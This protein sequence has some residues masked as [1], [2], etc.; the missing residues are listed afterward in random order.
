MSIE[1]FKPTENPFSQSYEDHIKNYWKFIC[2]LPK[3]KNPV[4]DNNG[5]KDEIVN[6]NSNAPVFYLN[7]SRN[8]GSF[9]ERTCKVPAGKGLFIPVM[10][11]EVSDKEVQNSTPER[12]KTIAKK[13]QDSVK[14]D[15]SVRL[16]GNEVSNLRSFRVSTDVFQIEFPENAIFDV[17]P[18]SSQ[19]VADGFY[20]ITKPL[21][22]GTH[23]IDFKG[24]LESTEEDSIEQNYSVNVKYTLEVQ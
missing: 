23:T 10:C 1:I 16:D 6:Q 17:S 21:S 15:L 8:G 22:P 11:V 9:V 13:D 2:R 5:Q 24:S 20:I 7:F 3:D 4:I 18:G 14:N 19:A 12:L